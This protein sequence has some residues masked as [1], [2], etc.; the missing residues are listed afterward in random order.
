MVSGMGKQRDAFFAGEMYVVDVRGWPADKVHPARPLTT[1]VPAPA[2][3]RLGVWTAHPHDR[4]ALPAPAESVG[5]LADVERF[6]LGHS[7]NRTLQAPK[8][9]WVVEFADGDDLAGMERLNLKAMYNDPSQMREALAWRLFEQVDVPAPRHTYA[10]LGINGTYLGLFSV[11]EHVDRSFLRS[12]FGARDHGNL[13]KVGCGDLGCGTLER[14]LGSDGDDSGRQ[15]R[16]GKDDPTYRLKSFADRPDAESC[17]DL[18]LLIR[19]VDGDGL[20]GGDGRFATD[21]YAASVRGVFAVEDFL[22]WAGVNVLAG[23][24]DNYFATPANYYLYNAGRPRP[25]PEE[26]ADVMAEPFFSF[27]PWDYD[28]SFGIDYFGTQWQYTDLLDWPANTEAYHRFNRGA[29]RSRIPLVTNLLANTEFRR[30]YLDH[31]E[32]L[33]DGVMSPEAIDAAIGVDGA[34]A[35]TAG[36]LWDRVATSAYLESDSPFGWPVTRRQFLND[37]VYRAGLQQQELRRSNGLILGIH[38]YV[39]MRYDRAREQLRELRRQDP[40]GSSGAT[41]TSPASPPVP[42]MTI[43]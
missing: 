10:R 14:R 4:R 39:R 24:W 15:Y 40:A 13:F 34:S 6:S 43:G 1:R 25:A 21:A 28:N 12:R 38:H 8:R 37:E 5:R 23:S 7:G 16:R 31:V 30:Y 11:V 29:G 33:L 22:R 27:I 32:H 26:P 20:A 2:G 9:S 35:A 19:M 18:A 41:F 42:A 17:D 36:G 3:A